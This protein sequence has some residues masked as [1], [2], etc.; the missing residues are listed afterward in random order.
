MKLVF[1]LISAALLMRG[2]ADF[3]NDIY[4]KALGDNVKWDEVKW[5][6]EFFY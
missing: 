3:L 2:F 1:L 6:D 4:I 5:D